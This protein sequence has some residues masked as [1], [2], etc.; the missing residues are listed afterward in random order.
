MAPHASV[1]QVNVFTTNKNGN[2]KF[3]PGKQTKPGDPVQ[4]YAGD[5]YGDDAG[6]DE[7]RIAGF[8]II[9]SG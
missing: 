3:Y 8:H 5:D 4:L 9:V 6:I 2:K 7:K 1:F